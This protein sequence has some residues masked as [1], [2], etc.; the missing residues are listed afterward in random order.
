MFTGLVQQIGK[1]QDLRRT[2]GGTLLR[3]SATYTQLVLGE[4]I[5]HLHYLYYD[6][7]LARTVG[8]DCVARF[9]PG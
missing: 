2:P 8:A 5:A 9:A 1:V 7:K 3:V 6:G 4:S